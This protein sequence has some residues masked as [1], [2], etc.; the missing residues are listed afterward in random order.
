MYCFR[1][2]RLEYICNYHK[3]SAKGRML[4][5]SPAAAAQAFT[6]S[7]SSSIHSKEAFIECILACRVHDLSHTEGAEGADAAL[8]G[9]IRVTTRT[10]HRPVTR[11]LL[12]A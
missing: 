8:C 3:T 12:I 9:R 4:K 2:V 1:V 10:I 11:A 7:S 5:H 6:S